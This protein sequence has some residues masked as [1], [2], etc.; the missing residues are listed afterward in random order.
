MMAWAMVSRLVFIVICFAYLE[1]ASLRDKLQR[2]LLVGHEIRATV[3]GDDNRAAGIA[4]ARGLV[5]N[6]SP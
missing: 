4:H 1:S 6:P 2:F 3:T 5:S